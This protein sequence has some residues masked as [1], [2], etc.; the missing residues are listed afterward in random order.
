MSSSRQSRWDPERR[1]NRRRRHFIPRMG[2]ASSTVTLTSPAPHHVAPVGRPVH[3]LRLRGKRKNRQN[4]QA[5]GKKEKKDISKSDR[6]PCQKCGGFKHDTKKCQSPKHLIELYQKSSLGKKAQGSGFEAQFNQ[7]SEKAKESSI[8]LPEGPS[9]SVP[10]L[11]IEDYM[12]TEN[13]IIE[14][15]L[16]DVFGD[17]V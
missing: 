9:N 1:E 13:T 8:V 15:I 4:N 12:D 14:L 2:V 16:S 11:T 17:L 10:P 6:Y 7:E 5:K 3:G